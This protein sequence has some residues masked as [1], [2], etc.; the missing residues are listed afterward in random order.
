MCS[1]TCEG[2]S[3]RRDGGRA[4]HGLAVHLHRRPRVARQQ[5]GVVFPQ[6][7]V[8]QRGEHE[9]LGR[10]LRRADLREAARGKLPEARRGV[11]PQ[12]VVRRDPKHFVGP[13]RR[14]AEERGRCPR[15]AGQLRPARVQA[16]PEGRVLLPQRTAGDHAVHDGLA[17]AVEAGADRLELA[18]G[19]FPPPVAGQCRAVLPQIASVGHDGVDRGIARKVGRRAH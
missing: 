16:G 3:R 11:F 19:D 13:A 4:R 1:A 9:V 6:L 10:R 7:A 2:C 17:R 15:R 14:R 18:V 12:R 5:S 8:G